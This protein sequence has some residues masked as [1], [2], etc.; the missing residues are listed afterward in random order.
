[1]PQ[2]KFSQSHPSVPPRHANN[3]NTLVQD[4]ADVGG[5]SDE[6]SFDEDTG[7]SRKRTNGTN[8]KGAHFDDSSEEESDDDDEEAQRAVGLAVT[9]K[10]YEDT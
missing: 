6:E 7:E 5:E 8:G 3:M 2:I 9:G 1:M 10:A 4:E